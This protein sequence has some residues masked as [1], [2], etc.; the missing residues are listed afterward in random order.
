MVCIYHIV[1]VF[2]VYQHYFSFFDVI[3]YDL[4]GYSGGLGTLENFSYK[5][6]VI[7]SLHY[8][9]WA[10]AKF[11]RNSLLSD[12]EESLWCTLLVTLQLAVYLSLPGC[13]T[14]GSFTLIIDISITW[15]LV[16]YANIWVP[17]Q[18]Y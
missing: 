12:S 2:T 4:I 14:Q 5:L 10:Y 13:I 11:Y 6:M 16:R 3:W 8:T 18:T 1:P 9:M 7:A 15:D 17:P